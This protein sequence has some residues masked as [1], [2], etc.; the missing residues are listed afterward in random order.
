MS[1]ETTIVVK[2]GDDVGDNALAVVELDE[3]KNIYVDNSGEIQIK[4]TFNSDDAPYFWIHYDST[5]VIEKI[6][7][8]AGEVFSIEENK[9]YTKEQQ[10]VFIKEKKDSATAKVSL[11]YNMHQQISKTWFGNVGTGWKKVNRDITITGGLNEFDLPTIPAICDFVFTILADQY[12]LVPPK[13]DIDAFHAIDAN[14]EKPYPILI[15]FYL[16]RKP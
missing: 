16:G 1:V 8:S 5:L 3:T 2:F 6:E 11:S 12:K 13:A 9:I 4:T 10:L 7:K 14:K 15:V